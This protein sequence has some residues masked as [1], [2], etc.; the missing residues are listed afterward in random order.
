MKEKKIIAQ[1]IS[2]DIE[3]NSRS[4]EYCL[5]DAIGWQFSQSRGHVIVDTKEYGLVALIPVGMIHV[6]SINF[7]KYIK[8]G[9]D[10]KK[11]DMLGSF[12]CGGSEFI[13]LFQEKAGFKITAP[14]D[15]EEMY[16][17]NNSSEGYPIKKF[18]HILMGEEYGRMKGQV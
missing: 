5:I 17:Q 11:G 15:K 3:W 10:F 8:V 2:L 7:E 1:N 6:S 13:M 16:T 18:K 12:T 14:L 4:R 9:D